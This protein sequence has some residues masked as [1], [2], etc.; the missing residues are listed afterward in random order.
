[1]F[2]M[3]M[4]FFNSI[5]SSGVVIS[6]VIDILYLIKKVFLLLCVFSLLFTKKLN[7]KIVFIV[8]IVA[9][10]FG[11]TYLLF[12]EN[13]AF[14][15]DVYFDLICCVV[16]LLL[17]INGDVDL[18]KLSF[19]LIILSR[20][21][22][23]VCIYTLFTKTNLNYYI[24][25]DYMTFSNGVIVPLGLIAF[26][27]CIYNK[28]LDW[29]IFGSG[30]IVLLIYGS[31]GSFLT[32]IV[33]LM[34]LFY[35]RMK[36][37]KIVLVLTLLVSVVVSFLVSPTVLL[38]GYS[39]R[40]IGK[41][42]ANSLFDLNGR[43]EIWTYLFKCSFEDVFLG[44]GLCGDR[45]YLSLIYSTSNQVYAHNFFLELFVDFG[46]VG[47]G[48]GLFL[49][50]RLMVYLIN[51]KN[52]KIK[53]LVVIFTFVSFLQLMFSRSFLTETGLFFMFGIIFTPKYNVIENQEE[54]NESQSICD[55]SNL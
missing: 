30:L 15:S 31:R 4:Q 51:E 18:D 41:I 36:R 29:A 34:F 52:T 21:A 6:S 17:L 1:M 3:T 55:H 28:M 9:I 8:L 33:L 48:F 39:S 26:S 24:T 53:T 49:V 5:E 11:T 23:I 27:I 20:I 16:C 44:H 10:V 22:I 50:Y 14:M 43:A 35:E 42:V 37:H 12:G 32:L 2:T 25:K 13:L 38:E 19:F 47:L 40:T 54:S 7:V 46:V 45:Y